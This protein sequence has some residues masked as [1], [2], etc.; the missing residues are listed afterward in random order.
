MNYES[1]L[2]TKS[3]KKLMHVLIKNSD[4]GRY[5]SKFNVITL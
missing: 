5:M 1:E 3:F 2:K 4:K